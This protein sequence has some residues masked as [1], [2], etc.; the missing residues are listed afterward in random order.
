[1]Y[2]KVI[3]I[4]SKATKE[5]VKERESEGEMEIPMAAFHWFSPILPLL[6]LP[7]H[8]R[9]ESDAT[10]SHASGKHSQQSDWG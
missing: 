5:R 4:F 9:G 2:H 1:M 3:F 10:L 8:G 7:P 6:M